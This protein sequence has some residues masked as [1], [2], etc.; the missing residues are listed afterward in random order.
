MGFHGPR[1]PALRSRPVKA[2]VFWLRVG[3]VVDGHVPLATMAR[4]VTISLK[5]FCQ[6]NFVFR[7]ATAI[8]GRHHRPGTSM[9]RGRRSAANHMSF[10]STSWVVATHNG[11]ARRCTGGGGSVGLPKHDPLFGELVQIGC[12]HGG[13]FVDVITF[14]VLPAEV[15]GEYQNN[16]RFCWTAN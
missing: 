13:W 4:R 12:F 9:M 2:L 5:D 14:Y 1:C 3:V 10:L 7:H 6:C 11:A 15:I 16:I 8:P